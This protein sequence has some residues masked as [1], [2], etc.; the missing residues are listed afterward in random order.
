M[1]VCLL[2][3][4]PRHRQACKSSCATTSWGLLLAD[5][6]G[7]GRLGRLPARDSR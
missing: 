1:M 4:R 7:P 5:A 2:V 3:P 6:P